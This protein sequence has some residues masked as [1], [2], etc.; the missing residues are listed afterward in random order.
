MIGHFTQPKNWPVQHGPTHMRVC[1]CLTFTKVQIFI[2]LKN[3]Y[4]V[5]MS[6]LLIKRSVSVSE[7]LCLQIIAGDCNLTSDIPCK[8]FL[9][10]TSI[11]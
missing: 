7:R 4:K 5:S 1:L 11:Q 9:N 3:L 6:S 10:Q 2:Q 8:P